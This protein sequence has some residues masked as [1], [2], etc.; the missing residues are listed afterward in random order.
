MNTEPTETRHPTGISQGRQERISE[1]RAKSNVLNFA[2]LFFAAFS[3]LTGYS[4]FE[5]LVKHGKPM[6]A[7]SSQIALWSTVA[8]VCLTITSFSRSSANRKIANSMNGLQ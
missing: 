2:A 3:A 8:L 6:T 5:N 7:E 1:L 4:I